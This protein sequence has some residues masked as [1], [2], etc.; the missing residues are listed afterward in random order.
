MTKTVRVLAALALLA[1]FAAAGVAWADSNDNGGEGTYDPANN[2]AGMVGNV[3][4]DGWS[5]NDGT[6]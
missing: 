5:Y 2:R 4:L 1:Q 6:R 3:A